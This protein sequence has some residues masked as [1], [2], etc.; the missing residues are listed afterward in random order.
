MAADAERAALGVDKNSCVPTCPWNLEGDRGVGRDFDFG[1]GAIL[2]KGAG[3]RDVILAGQKS[4]DTWALD[5]QTG[6]KLWNVRFGQG[7]A[8]GGVHWGITTDG[9]RLFA[10][11]NDP[12]IPGAV[13][14][15]PGVYAVD[16]NTGK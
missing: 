10:A 2:A 15:H 6:K 14:P 3:G 4:G 5:A 7:T 1:A 13:T 9:T 8:L 11:I 12:V 16:I